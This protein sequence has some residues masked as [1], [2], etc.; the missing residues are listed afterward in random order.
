MKC[1]ID[2]KRYNKFK[3]KKLKTELVIHRSEVQKEANRSGNKS[4]KNERS[5]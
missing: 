1:P 5:R 2:K 4:Q 3:A